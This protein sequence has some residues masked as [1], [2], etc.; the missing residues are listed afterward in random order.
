[1]SVFFKRGD[2]IH[3]N[4]NRPI[5]PEQKQLVIEQAAS[6]YGD[7]LSSLGF[8]WQGDPNMADTPKRV[9][10]SF[11]N[12]LFAGVFNEAPDVTSFPNDGEDAYMGMI[13]QTNCEVNSV[14]AHHHLPFT[15][16]CHVAVIPGKQGRLI[17]LSKFNRL[18]DHFSRRPQIQE[19]LT[20]QITKA[21]QRACAENRGVAVMIEAEHSCCSNRGI[22]QKSTMITSNL[23]GYFLDNTLSSKAEFFQLVAQATKK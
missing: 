10:K 16:V 18:V 3:C 13:I 1:M 17:G 14:C 19:A 23:T 4:Q 9:A 8:A 6:H 11:V 7:F 5:T 21:I 12:D 15:G 2:F 22:G 20:T